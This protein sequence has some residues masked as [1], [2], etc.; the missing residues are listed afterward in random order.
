MKC[1]NINLVGLW[2]IR[3]FIDLVVDQLIQVFSTG[4]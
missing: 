1:M 2:V 4:F 3:Y